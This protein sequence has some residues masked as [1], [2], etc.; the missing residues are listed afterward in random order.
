MISFDP[1]E[2][3]FPP[4]NQDPFPSFDYFFDQIKSAQQSLDN[5]ELLLA[6]MP[7]SDGI[8]ACVG[9]CLRNKLLLQTPAARCLESLL[10]AY[11]EIKNSSDWLLL[12]LF[13]APDELH[14]ASLGPNDLL[15]PLQTLLDWGAN[16]N[17]RDESGNSPLGLLNERVAQI[18]SSWSL[19]NAKNAY[20][21]CAMALLDGGALPESV[22][23]A[24]PIDR[25]V[26]DPE[27]LALLRAQMEARQIRSQIEK[28]PPQSTAPF[29]QTNSA[30]AQ[31]CEKDN[32]SKRL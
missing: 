6:D 22:L 19:Q 21:E 4:Q 13:Q 28:A 18:Q 27:L 2:T 11:P 14:E 26:S 8:L 24:P 1:K 12:S 15:P 32:K 25:V 31:E 29:A 10:L 3:G 23:P 9:F 7:L 16:P 20:L 17:C 5:Y 30:A